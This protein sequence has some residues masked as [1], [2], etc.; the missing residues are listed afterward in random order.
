MSNYNY[1]ELGATVPNQKTVY[2]HKEPV[3]YDF[4]QVSNKEWQYAS[5]TLEPIGLQLYL[6][7]AA[8]KDKFKLALSKSAANNA[9]GIKHTS[10][11]KYLKQLEEEGY[12]VPR[13][14]SDATYDFYTTPYGQGIK[15]A[16]SQSEQSISPDEKANTPDEKSTLQNNIEID[17]SNR[18]IQTDNIDGEEASL[19]EPSP[20]VEREFYF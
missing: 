18:D 12:L 11:Y 1:F 2:I 4:L 17:N 9:I 15:T 10:Y 7:L 19:R 20:P 13:G 14:D 6:Y 8:N 5:R 16:I 3:N